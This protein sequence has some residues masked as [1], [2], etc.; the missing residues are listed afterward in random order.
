VNYVADD[1]MLEEVE[2]SGL[3]PTDDPEFVVFRRA[4]KIGV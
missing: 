4:N 1:D 2:K 3:A